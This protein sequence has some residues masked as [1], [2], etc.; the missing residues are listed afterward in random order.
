MDNPF[1]VDYPD[2]YDMNLVKMAVEGDREALQT[3]ISR[4]HIFVY[5]LALKMTKSIEDAEDMSQEVFIKVITAL[6]QFKGKS[7]FRTWLYRITVNHILNA[8][9]RKTEQEITGF[10]EYGQFLAALPDGHL[11]EFEK[12]KFLGAIEE[13]RIQCTAGM[14]LCLDREQRMIFILGELFEI[15]HNLGAEIFGISKGNFRI[16]LMRARQDLH[17]WMH[18]NCGLVHKANPCRCAKKTKHF[19]DAGYVDPDNLKF[20]SNYKQKIYELS[21][22]SANDLMDSVEDMHRDIY[23]S[24]PLQEPMD[25]SIMMSK[26]LSNELIRNVMKI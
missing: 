26:I 16:R 14:L 3:L 12:N 22:K 13:I 18:E 23:Q 8:E 2:Q 25:S 4:H 1:V 5:N 15:D 19:I 20:N 6:S 7:R 17:N 11:T 24:H 10:E 21:E 9:K